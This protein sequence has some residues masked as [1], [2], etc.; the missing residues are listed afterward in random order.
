MEAADEEE[1]AEGNKV[2]FLRFRLDAACVMHPRLNAH[3]RDQESRS[4]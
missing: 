2:I 3:L 1:L 4:L